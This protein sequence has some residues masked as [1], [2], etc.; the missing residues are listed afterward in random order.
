MVKRNVYRRTHHAINTPG[1]AHYLTFSCYKRRAFLSR[2][3]TRQYFLDAM[4]RARKE[5]EFDLWAYAIMSNHAHLLIFPRRENYDMGKIETAIKVSVSRRALA[6]LRTYNPKGLRHLA[7]GHV[8]TPYRF[9]TSGNGYDKNVTALPATNAIADYI[10]NNPVRAGLCANPEDWEWS[11]A[12]EWMNE[13]SGPVRID[14]DS[15][16]Y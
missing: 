15:Y 3:R 14:R 4:E 10:H 8:H 5:H 16:P 2:D 12:R 9:W 1:E 13:G 6:Y 11:S 7:T